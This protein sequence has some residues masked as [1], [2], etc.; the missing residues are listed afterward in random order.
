MFTATPTQTEQ[1]SAHYALP[2]GRRYW[3]CEELVRA[4]A[5][6]D[7]GDVLEVGCGNGANLWYLAEHSTRAVGVDF[8]AEALDEARSYTHSRGRAVELI[9]GD[10]TRL[11]FPDGTFDSLVDCMVSQHVPYA[12]HLPLYKEYAR[13]LRPGGWLFLYHLT[14]RTTGGRLTAAIHPEH[15]DT[16]KVPLFPAAGFTCLSTVGALEIA[17]MGAGFCRTSRSGL[18]REYP[19]GNVAHYA[20]ITAFKGE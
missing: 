20:V 19:A 2:S 6:R 3:P 15:A 13:V 9:Q 7:L 17:I 10:I 18:Q 8:C 4:V 14:N 16:P 11:P 1:W 5:G 12:A